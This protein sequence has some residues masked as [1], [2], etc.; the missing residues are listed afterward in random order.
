MNKGQVNFRW[1][2]CWRCKGSG[3]YLEPLGDG[4]SQLVECG[5]CEG[6]GKRKEAFKPGVPMHDYKPPFPHR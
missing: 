3:Q 5:A 4:E 6:R 2:Q 1:V